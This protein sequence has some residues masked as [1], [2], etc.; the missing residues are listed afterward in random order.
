MSVLFSDRQREMSAT[1]RLIDTLQ[2][3]QHLSFYQMMHYPVPR[4]KEYFMD[5]PLPTKQSLPP[6]QQKFSRDEK[7]DLMQEYLKELQ[8]HSALYQSLPFVEVIYLCNSLTFNALHQHSD[9]DFFIIVRPERI[10]TAK[11]FAMLKMSW[12]GIKRTAHKKVKKICLSFFVTADHQNL[13]PLSVRGVDVYLAYW[14]AHLVPLYHAAP[15]KP[16]QIRERNRRVQGVLPN[17]P[18]EQSIVLD[19]P[20][21]TGETPGKQRRERVL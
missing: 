9:I 11:F 4:Q 16:L 10:W 13:Y 15:T 5:A 7:P 8:Q 6:L 21:I 20:L 1:T 17:F 2:S 3:S 18:G 19:M 14:I 12:K